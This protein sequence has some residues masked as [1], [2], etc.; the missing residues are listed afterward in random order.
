MATFKQLFIGIGGHGAKSLREIRKVIY[1]YELNNKAL[2][3]ATSASATPPQLPPY[4][5]LAIDSSP[6]ILNAP[7][8]WTHLGKNLSL[9]ASEFCM[10]ESNSIS[11]SAPNIT[12]WLYS[13]DSETAERQH[14]VFGRIQKGV[15]GA[16]QRRRYGRALFASNAAKVHQSI[17]DAMARV[18]A[19]D[20]SQSCVI[21]VFCSL[22][23]GT[24]SGGIVDLI[25]MLREMYPVDQTYDKYQAYSIN[26]YVY[27]ADK[28]G[29]SPDALQ[30]YFFENQ[31][32]A[33]RDLN[34]LSTGML[35]PH[36]LLGSHVGSRLSSVNPINAIIISTNTTSKSESIDIESQVKRVAKWAVD[37]AFLTESSDS[38]VVKIATGE[39]FVTNAPGEPH[40]DTAGKMFVE[41][42]YNFANLGFAKWECPVKELLLMDTHSIKANSFKQMLY[43]NLSTTDG[44]MGSFVPLSDN[45]KALYTPIPWETYLQT[46]VISKGW[47]D[48]ADANFG[49]DGPFDADALNKMEKAFDKFYNEKVLDATS[50]EAGDYL[51]F[52]GRKEQLHNAL[53]TQLRLEGHTATDVT[54]LLFAALTRDLLN[55]WKDAKIGLLQAADAA[56][57]VIAKMKKN[58]EALDKAYS[59]RLDQGE[60]MAPLTENL[61]KRWTPT[62]GEWH[63]LTKLSYAI[64][65]KEF[66]TAHKK[67]LIDIYT[68]KT[69]QAN[70]RYAMEQL[71]AYI[72]KINTFQESIARRISYMETFVA[73]EERMYEATNLY[74]FLYKSQS[75]GLNQQLEYD[76][77]NSDNSYREAVDYIRVNTTNGQHTIVS[78]AK[79]LRDIVADTV[80]VDASGVSSLAG[81]FGGFDVMSPAT[82][83][84]LT[85]KSYELAGA[86]QQE[87]DEA[88]Q[89]HWIG[90]IVDRMRSLSAGEIRDKF[91]RLLKSA[92]YSY[93]HCSHTPAPESAYG[94]QYAN[95]L[96]AKWVVTFPAGI[97]FADADNPGQMLSTKDALED[98]IARVSGISKQV[99]KVDFSPDATKISVWQTEYQRPAR[100]ADVINYLHDCY[101]EK[102]TASGNLIANKFWLNIDDVATEMAA[103]LTFPNDEEMK[104]LIAA[105][106]W[107]VKESSGAFTI[108]ENTGDIFRNGSAQDNVSIYNTK[109][110]VGVDYMKKT[111]FLAAVQKHL[112]EE[113]KKNNAL[114]TDLKQKYEAALHSSDRTASLNFEPLVDKFIKPTLY[115]IA[116]AEHIQGVYPA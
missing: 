20:P 81:L 108:D 115:R 49:V 16:Q 51:S 104:T 42:S 80:R 69:Q 47:Q 53:K 55:G 76:Y 95:V 66:L 71:E 113:V 82:I 106:L 36:S 67:D 72:K 32:A 52:P 63:K 73:D 4:A 10:L 44:Y 85:T 33:L 27:L 78:N 8:A 13:Q 39:D 59:A 107:V 11:L 65:G 105:A 23:G 19:K 70:I 91:T 24:G 89:T 109:K 64:K 18:S 46:E 31:Y 93:K 9:N 48:W 100:T 38:D 62:S 26:L 21:N 54:S 3:S 34:A 103:P 88:K 96:S 110:T 116:C 102:I 37:R 99:L 43:N 90:G 87:A 2:A 22:G 35:K 5:F 61:H 58:I 60:E 101:Q 79:S 6:D 41:R 28:Q 83:E 7:A 86:M 94:A 30:G 45:Q 50:R 57:F 112:Y 25:A 68:L 77:N 97:A 1:E 17:T 111:S 75:P 14:E 40:P 84:A 56:K 114:L 12:P 98:Y 74:R 29:V 15:P 92:T